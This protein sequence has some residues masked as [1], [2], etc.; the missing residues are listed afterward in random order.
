MYNPNSNYRGGGTIVLETNIIDRLLLSTLP[1]DSEG[2]P[3]LGPDDYDDGRTSTRGTLINAI[4][5]TGSTLAEFLKESES[6]GHLGEIKLNYI[7]N[8]KGDIIEWNIM[9]TM[10]GK[11]EKQL[12]GIMTKSNALQY[13]T[14]SY[15]QLKENA[16]YAKLSDRLFD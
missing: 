11:G 8:N 10:H 4:T 9:M 15:N 1:Y 2:I 3:G 5:A 13:L 7:T 14:E 6:G 16:Q 12:D